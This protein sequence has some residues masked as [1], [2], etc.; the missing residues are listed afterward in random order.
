[1][2]SNLSVDMSLTYTDYEQSQLIG[3]PPVEIP[4]SYYDT[5]AV[6]RVNR[7]SSGGKI[8]TSLEVGYLNRSGGENYDGW[9]TGLRA[10][11]QP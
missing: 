9:W 3:N 2:A 8:T 6:G 7:T 1:L 4:S 10:R 5:Q 11:W